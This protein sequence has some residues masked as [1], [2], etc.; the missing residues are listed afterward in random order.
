VQLLTVPTIATTLVSDYNFFGIMCSVLSSFFLT[1]QIIL[2]LGDR[3][4]ELR[5]N[6]ERRAFITRKYYN[7]FHDLRY[8]INP[9]AVRR[10][11]RN[12]P[13]LL[14]QY[15]DFVSIFQGMNPIVRQSGLH[16]E[17]ESTA[18]IDAFNVTLQV[19]KIGRRFSD[20]FQVRDLKDDKEQL[21]PLQLARAIM[22]VL[23]HLMDW[24]PGKHEVR[25][26]ST[27][28]LQ[29]SQLRVAGVQEQEFHTV[30]TINAGSF[31]VVKFDVCK[32]PV[33]FHQ[34]VHW[35]LSE[36]LENVHL[37]D[38]GILERAGW[39]GGIKAMVSKL[40]DIYP[41]FSPNDTILSILDWPMRTMVLLCQIRSGFWV[42]NGF[43]VRNQVWKQ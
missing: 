30:K 4:S 25:D 21:A 5:I 23:K 27:P 37:L 17:Y 24:I 33:S 39:S 12:E 34:P 7:A 10:Y 38:D 22:R 13:L 15:L 31:S 41:K 29:Y 6:C 35:L 16:V 32:D 42:R 9:D 1:D 20:A 43:G 3:L 36:L 28:F 19:A 40:H 18:W 11:I 8:I 2:P 14:R 26:E